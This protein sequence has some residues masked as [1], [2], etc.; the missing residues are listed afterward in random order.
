MNFDY[1]PGFRLKKITVDSFIIKDSWF[2]NNS[3]GYI[4]FYKKWFCI[5]RVVIERE[6]YT[7]TRISRMFRIFSKH[8]REI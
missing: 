4:T 5:N 1:Y 2:D 3:L 7:Y 8:W 6:R